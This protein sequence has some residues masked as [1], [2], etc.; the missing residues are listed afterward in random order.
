MT[1]EM[2]VTAGQSVRSQGKTRLPQ[3]PLNHLGAVLVALGVVVA[4]GTAALGD[5]RL[6]VA[7]PLVLVPA[8]LALLW[9]YDR[10]T[11][12]RQVQGLV[13]LYL[14]FLVVCTAADVRWEILCGEQAQRSLRMSGAW[15]G[16]LLLAAGRLAQKHRG[17]RVPFSVFPQDAPLLVAIGVLALHAVALTLLLWWHYGYGWEYDIQM[18][19]RVGLCV[20][21]AVLIVPLAHS[22]WPRAIVGILSA[23]WLVWMA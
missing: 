8:A 20:V 4:A 21:V 2:D 14:V 6:P 9:P 19:G 23:L 16:L 1:V 5:A 22:P 18:S 13:L 3:N 12:C 11:G 7:Q 17:D 15:P 10:P